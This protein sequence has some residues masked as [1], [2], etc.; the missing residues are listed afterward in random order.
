MAPP[1]PQQQSNQNDSG[2]GPLWI[3]ACV[4][5]VALLIWYIAGEHIVWAVLKI[6]MGE[7]WLISFI[8]SSIN[9]FRDAVGH[10]ILQPKHVTFAQLVVISTV[11][12]EYV[13]I[14]AAI[15]LG[16]MAILLYFSSVVIQ[17]KRTYNMKTLLAAEKENWPQV[18]P[19]SKLNLLK[20]PINEGP[21]AMTIPPLVFAKKYNLIREE[22]LPLMEDELSREV[23]VIAVLKRQAASRI[24]AMQLGELWQGPAHIPVYAR[25]LF[26]IF[27][28]R[29]NHDTDAASKLLSQISQSAETGRLDFTGADALLRKYRSTKVVQFLEKRHA[30]VFSLMASMLELARVDGVLASAEFIW[31]KPL[32]R[33]L[34]YTL[35]TVGRQTAPT[36]VA[37]IFAHWITEKELGRRLVVPM[38]EEATNALEQ[39]LQEIL[40]K[41]DEEEKGAK[42]NKSGSKAATHKAKVT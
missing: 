11:V 33:R 38:V 24:F 21:W 39:A 36:E 10:L 23:R 17:F 19:V 13:A 7:M 27:A 41:P 18:I 25:A 14:P 3:I 35:N 31:L 28:A 30:Y 29:A 12:G 2:L 37:G 5:L 34:W 32:D 1:A 16:M 42:K 4:F 20:Q 22:T 6:R 9:V 40:Y 15:M 26:A 8:T